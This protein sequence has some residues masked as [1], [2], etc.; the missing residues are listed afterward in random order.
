MQD[1]VNLRVLIALGLTGGC[2]AHELAENLNLAESAVLGVLDQLE[3]H[4][5][6]LSTD[7]QGTRFYLTESGQR[8]YQAIYDTFYQYEAWVVD[9]QELRTD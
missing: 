9:T 4:D 8:V 2:S 1:C 5:P 6:P 7:H 3:D